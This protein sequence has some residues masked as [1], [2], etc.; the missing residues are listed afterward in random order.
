[1]TYMFYIRF[2][3]L[4]LHRNSMERDSGRLLFVLPHWGRNASAPALAYVYLFLSRMTGYGAPPCGHGVADG[5]R[6]GIQPSA[7]AVAVK[8]KHRTHRT[9]LRRRWGRCGMAYRLFILTSAFLPGQRFACTLYIKWMR[10][11][12]FAAFYILLDVSFKM[13]SRRN[14]QAGI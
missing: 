9:H 11:C 1:M 6:P 3:Y 7:V 13:I 10:F 5:G 2:C 12:A 4:R 14:R 8:R